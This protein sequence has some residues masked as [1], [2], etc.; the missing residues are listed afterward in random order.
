MKQAGTTDGS[1]VREA[2]ENLTEKVDGVVTTYVKP[3][4]H[5][6]HEAIKAGMPVMG[7]AKD[8]HIVLAK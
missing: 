2:L 4:S 8:G 1:K 5:D 6:D 3:F 7:E